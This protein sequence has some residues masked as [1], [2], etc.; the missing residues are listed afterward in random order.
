[1]LTESVKLGPEGDPTRP[2]PVRKSASSRY[3]TLSRRRAQSFSPGRRAQRFWQARPLPAEWTN[4]RERPRGEVGRR[5]YA[6]SRRWRGGDRRG[7]TAS[8][9]DRRLG[10]LKVMCPAARTI[11]VAGAAWSV[12]NAAPPTRAV[13]GNAAL[14]LPPA[15]RRASP[16][17]VTDA[18]A[19]APAAFMAR[20]EIRMVF[21]A[22]AGWVR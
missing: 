11:P 10:G 12:F 19:A 9:F 2:F 15:T 5:E 17:A 13:P 4:M 14:A 20:N 6:I 21:V 16:T 22:M 7:F 8:D 1:M 3:D 18:R